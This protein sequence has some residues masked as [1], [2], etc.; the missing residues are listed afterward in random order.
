M[1]GDGLEDLAHRLAESARCAT[2]VALPALVV[3]ALAACA[4]AVIGWHRQP[5][6]HPLDDPD[7]AW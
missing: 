2:L 6:T 3:S 4:G 5:H 1:T 7:A